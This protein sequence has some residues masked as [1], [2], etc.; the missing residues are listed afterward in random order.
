MQLK[1]VI[2]IEYE[3]CNENKTLVMFEK[4]NFIYYNL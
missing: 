1:H 3:I 2:E 4:F